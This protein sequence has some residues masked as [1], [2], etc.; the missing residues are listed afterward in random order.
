MTLDNLPAKTTKVF[1]QRDVRETPAATA[2]A[3]SVGLTDP[4]YLTL[5]VDADLTNERVLTAGEGIDFT[6]NGA[7]G[8]L[9]INGEHATDTGNKG[10]ATFDASDFDVAA[11]VV[12]IDDSGVDH[13]AITNTH[14]MTTDIDARITP[15]EGINYTTG[16][17][18]CELATETNAGI[19][20]FDGTDFTVTTG[21]VTLKA[22]VCMSIDGDSGTATP[23]SH[24]IDILGGEGIDTAG[25][26]NDITISGED[27]S[28]TN[29]GIAQFAA[30]DGI[31]VDATS[32]TITY[33][34]ES[35][36]TSNVGGVELATIAETQTGTDEARAVT[37][38]SL[39]EVLPPVGAIIAWAKSFT[40][41]PQTLPVGW[42]ECDGSVISDAE[43]LLN[44][45]TLPDLNGGEFLEGR[46]TSG[47]TGGSATMAHTHTIPG[48][49]YEDQLQVDASSLVTTGSTDDPD[50]VIDQTA[51]GMGTDV[52]RVTTSA[53]SNTENRPPFYTVVW[54]MRIK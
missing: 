28:T 44:G 14:N 16:T 46:A 31:D 21:D 29:K 38:N 25:S 11:G 23:S 19:A 13:D 2:T 18:S 10:I 53:A 48:L 50:V 42:V 15:G 32:G 33:S 47:G 52:S 41:V 4:Q 54:I 39:F 17:I 12:T 5:A 43:S 51:S 9:V 1:S 6:D 3:T 35:A 26:G 24:N 45:E 8:T 34:I 30:G 40:S 49:G 37:P 27:A 36:T 7:G 20:T 22:T